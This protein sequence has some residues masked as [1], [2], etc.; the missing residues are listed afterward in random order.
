MSFGQYA[1]SFNPDSGQSTP[2]PTPSHSTFVVDLNANMRQLHQ[3]RGIPSNPD[4]DLNDHVTGPAMSFFQDRLPFW[5]MST[6]FPTFDLEYLGQCLNTYS[7]EKCVPGVIGEFHITFVKLIFVETFLVDDHKCDSMLRKINGFVST[8]SKEDEEAVKSLICGELKKEKL[9]GKGKKKHDES[10]DIF[11]PLLYNLLCVDSTSPRSQ[12]A[13]NLFLITELLGHS[14][15]E[16]IHGVRVSCSLLCSTNHL[17]QKMFLCVILHP[18]FV[19]ILIFILE[20]YD[21]IA[22]LVRLGQARLPSYIFS[23]SAFIVRILCS[24]RNRRL[25]IAQTFLVLDSFATYGCY[26]RKQNRS[27]EDLRKILLAFEKYFVVLLTRPDF[28]KIS[29]DLYTI[30]TADKDAIDGHG[31]FSR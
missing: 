15:P 18:D 16:F 28:I 22:A 24:K 29:E 1:L 12:L 17:P 26:V 30:I 19:K 2:T 23:Y 21:R 20:R 3:I 5:M 6:P 27:I 10:N 9:T 8:F 11:Q 25:P 31:R 13:Q 7:Y 4:N 14:N